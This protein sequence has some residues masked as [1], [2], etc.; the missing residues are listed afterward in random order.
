MAT[1]QVRDVPEELTRELKVRAASEGRSL[2]QY[3]LEQLTEL[4]SR[5]TKQQ[6]VGIIM[7]RDRP[8][9][10]DPAEELRQA[11]EQG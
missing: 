11:R 3:V 6:V 5:P 9:V 4:V 1:L 7:S 10:S 8:E 2:S